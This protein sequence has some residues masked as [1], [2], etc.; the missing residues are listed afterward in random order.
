[1]TRFGPPPRCRLLRAFGATHRAAA[2]RA[3][4]IV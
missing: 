1:M 3:P 4:A 2:E